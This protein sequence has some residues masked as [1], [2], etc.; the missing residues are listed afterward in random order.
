M[1]P[2]VFMKSC[3]NESNFEQFGG[4]VCRCFSRVNIQENNDEG[5]G[6]CINISIRPIYDNARK[7]NVPN[8]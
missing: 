6:N 3:I 4:M 5:D 7:M 8:Q 1:M 2:F